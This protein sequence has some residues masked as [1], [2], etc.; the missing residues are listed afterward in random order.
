MKYIIFLLLLIII[1]PLFTPMVPC[2]LIKTNKH[3]FDSKDKKAH[4]KNPLSDKP[5]AELKTEKEK[6][7]KAKDLATAVKYLDAMRGVCTDPEI[8]E[9]ILLEMADIYFELQDWTK[10][11]RAYNEFVLL[12]PGAI[13]CDYAHYRAIICG[14]KINTIS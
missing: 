9:D 2:F 10:S 13:R 7:L 6:A 12:Y 1:L 4:K 14:M 3:Q 5:F 8:F 11:E